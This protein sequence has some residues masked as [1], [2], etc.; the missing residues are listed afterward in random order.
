MTLKRLRANAVQVELG[1][2]TGPKW[3]LV[4]PLGEWHR[5]DYPDGAITVDDNYVASMVANF[6]KLPAGTWLPTDYHHWGSSN[7][8]MPLDNKV[9]S[10]WV[11]DLR[12][13]PSGLE[14]LI[15]WTDAARARIRAKELLQF[16]PEWFHNGIDITTGKPQGPTFAGGALLNDPYFL[17]HL[18]RVAATEQPATQN[19]PP[20][21]THMEKKKLIALLA[22]AGVTGLTEA[23]PESEIELALGK[24]RAA[25]PEGEAAKLSAAVSA[26][27]APLKAAL[28]DA[29]KKLA[30]QAEQLAKLEAKATADAT[31][32]L[33]SDLVRGRWNDG[34]QGHIV[35]AQHDQVRAYV[36]ACG[37]EE[38]QKF[39]AAM[40]AGPVLGEVGAAGTAPGDVNPEAAHKKLQAAAEELYAKGGIS[41]SEAL[42][43]AMRA[44][45][46]SALAAARLTSPLKSVTAKN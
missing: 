14:A 34:K 5:P 43:R 28:D 25:N 10:G 44:D 27:Q 20:K 36:K 2:E 30:A 22:A 24:L 3:H 17:G 31:E 21:E 1:A 29:H 35:A 38:A 46:A 26:G 6:K 33:I 39:F 8:V 12:A 42:E 15:D 16:S 11:H 9:A 13:S 18:P 4:M 23:T 32:A 40:K 37:V 45:E 19:Q 41:R 7:D